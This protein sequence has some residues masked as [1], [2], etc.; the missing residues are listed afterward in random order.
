MYASLLQT[1]T[2]DRLFVF[3]VLCVYPLSLAPLIFGYD[4]EFA[5]FQ[6]AH[7][8]STGSWE[9][10]TLSVHARCGDALIVLGFIRWLISIYQGDTF[11]RPLYY[12]FWLSTFGVAM[13]A[14]LSFTF[15]AG[16]QRALWSLTVISRLPRYLD[17]VLPVHFGTRLSWLLAGGSI[18]TSATFQRW[19]AFHLGLCL[20]LLWHGLFWRTV[21]RV[22][23]VV[24]RGLLVGLGVVASVAVLAV[25]VPETP[26]LIADPSRTPA[27]IPVVWHQW[28]LF[29][30]VKFVSPLQVFGI[31]A[32]LAALLAGPS[33]ALTGAYILLLRTY[34]PTARDSVPPKPCSGVV[35]TRECIDADVV[36][37]GA[38]V[39]S[40][41]AAIRLLTRCESTGLP[42]PRILVFEKAEKVGGHCLSGCVLDPRPLAC[43]LGSEL[44]ENMPIESRVSTEHIAF[45]TRRRW[46]E[47]PYIPH[48]LRMEGMP[49]ISISRLA[50]W[51]V[52]IAEEHGA[53]VYT[54]SSVVG[55]LEEGGRTVGVQ[56]GDTGLAADGARTG[57]FTP[58]EAV[59]ARAVVLGEGSQGVVTERLVHGKGLATNSA[60]QVYSQGIK[61][62]FRV[63]ENSLPAGAVWHTL[64]YPFG[65]M[66]GGGF[67]YGL[68]S[69]HICLGVVAALDYRDPGR[70]IY[71]LLKEFTSHPLIR[72]CLEG[73]ELIEYG[74]KLLPE[75]G[76]RSV[77]DLVTDGALIVGDGAGLLDSVRLK[78]VHIA[79][80]SGI[81]AGESLHECW[82]AGDFSADALEGYPKRMRDTRSWRE[83]ERARNVRDWF[84][85]GLM[86]GVLATGAALFSHGYLPPR[87]FRMGPDSGSL[88]G[89]DARRNGELSAGSSEIMN[90]L[91]TSRVRHREDQPPHVVI[92]QRDMCREVCIP[93]FGAPCVHFCPGRV[94]EH[95]DNGDCI[96]VNSANCLHCR[97]CA[98]KDPCKNIAWHLPEAG[99]GPRYSRM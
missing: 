5:Y 76:L 43:L 88:A 92:R 1:K 63:R 24:R 30:L 51:L 10:V 80:E 66:H 16:D 68:D 87:T 40:L 93:R 39:A 97:T 27:Q 35:V 8:F 89:M 19:Y 52:S 85:F 54:A 42:K 22:P 37:V 58:G 6:R 9:A 56:L 13:G 64:G 28:P 11:Q 59:R 26:G 25:A 83:L 61:Q 7:W 34:V 48:A 29:E 96:R 46:Y 2:I 75:G 90:A 95:S 94:F 74:A 69:Q 71:A 18:I 4:A 67:L 62:V 33:L 70:D 3:M 15:L 23:L 41:S 77:P 49:I 57:S 55:T 50:R 31:L 79:I 99:G 12:L 21:K 86:P 36:C 45:I 14:S 73:G 53:E 38:G 78:G 32:V 20:I 65:R 72:R 60:T 98:V 81:C 84:Q 82:E 47:L 44:I 91:Y 17:T